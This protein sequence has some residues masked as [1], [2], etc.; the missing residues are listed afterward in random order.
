[1]KLSED[2]LFRLIHSLTATEESR[3]IKYA[4]SQHTK[5]DTAYLK[6]FDIIRKQNIYDAK[7]IQQKTKE[8][9]S[10]AIKTKQYLYNTLI[11]HLVRNDQSDHPITQKVEMLYRQA[12][13]L[14]YKGMYKEAISSVSEAKK[15]ANKYDFFNL[16]TNII[17]LEISIIYSTGNDN[18]AECLEKAFTEKNNA[19]KKEA[20]IDQYKYMFACIGS[21][22]S[23]GVSP[24]NILSH[25]TIGKIIQ[26]EIFLNQEVSG[27]P[28]MAQYYFH[29]AHITYYG[30]LND[31]EKSFDHQNKIFNLWSR[32]PD[33]KKSSG[34]L[35]YQWLTNYLHLKQIFK[36][37]SNIKKLLEE[38]TPLGSSQL[39]QKA[40]YF[41][42]TN[43][44]KSRLALCAGNI[45]TSIKY[46]NIA[47]KTILL[48]E[49]SNLFIMHELICYLQFSIIY[50]MNADM[51]KANYYLDKMDTYH[52]FLVKQG[53]E[54]ISRIRIIRMMITFERG[55]YDLLEDFYEANKKYFDRKRVLSNLDITSLFMQFFKNILS[56]NNKQKIQQEFITLKN[57][58]LQDNLHRYVE[59]FIGF[60]V[61]IWIDSKITNKPMQLLL[62]EKAK[63]EYPEIFEIKL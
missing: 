27:L 51:Q 36:D 18:L 49:S 46:A 44:T 26:S 24:K 10:N 32:F 31:I 59:F 63:K 43:H 12:K 19:G 57:K 11:D 41:H 7:A 52:A 13:F 14:Y 58:L 50:F 25:P 28:F 62:K 5:D 53:W 35:Y 6:L 45:D 4:Q 15:E 16:L 30:L 48:Q 60:D 39:H 40:L 1:M 23:K 37:F 21:F 22:I 42:N 3:F 56:L 55:N 54:F 47:T 2:S 34:S 8:I 29:K 38:S 20:I 61:L 33:M 17:N 9:D